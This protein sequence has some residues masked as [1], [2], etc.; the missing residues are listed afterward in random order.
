MNLAKSLKEIRKSMGMS[1]I[2]AW[3]WVVRNKDGSLFLGVDL[4]PVRDE[5]CAVWRVASKSIQLLSC[6]PLGE[7]LIWNDDPRE[8]SLIPTEQLKESDENN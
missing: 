8:V 3:G 4:Y 1:E 5:P 2:K 6:D 7:G